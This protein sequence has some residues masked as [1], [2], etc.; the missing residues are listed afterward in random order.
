MYVCD[1]VFV[2]RGQPSE[3]VLSFFHEVARLGTVWSHLATKVFS[4]SQGPQQE[5]GVRW[6]EKES[7]REQESLRSMAWLPS[8]SLVEL[9][10]VPS[11]RMST[12]GC[13]PSHGSIVFFFLVF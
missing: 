8:K 10:G 12:A 1:C 4:V 2:V 7:R 5:R 13:A 3:L 9:L 11:V 6:E